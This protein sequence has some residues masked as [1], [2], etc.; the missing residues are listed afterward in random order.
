V[1]IGS[2]NAGYVA[3]AIAEIEGLRRQ[4]EELEHPKMPEPLGYPDVNA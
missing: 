4:V 3:D 2:A 1:K